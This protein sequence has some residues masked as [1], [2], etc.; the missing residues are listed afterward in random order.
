MNAKVGRGLDGEEGIIGLHGLDCD[1]NDNGERFSSFC[2]INNLAV[3]T[4]MFKHK[5]IHLQM[6]TSPNGQHRNQIDHE[7]VN[8]K[9]KRSVLN[10]RVF[11]GTNVESDHNLVVN[12]AKLK[13]H[14][15][16]A[17]YETCKLKSKEIAERFRIELRNRFSVLEE[18]T[19]D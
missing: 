17:R 14:K 7:A 2:A 11:R 1:R 13:L 6:W 19:T 15:T 3:V 8:V 18:Q 4:T 5:D 12:R 10:A 16:S 9:Y